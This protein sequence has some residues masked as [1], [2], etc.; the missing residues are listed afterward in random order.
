MVVAS[1]LNSGG[2]QD[3]LPWSERPNGPFGVSWT[4]DSDS[5][6]PGVIYM[7]CDNDGYVGLVKLENGRIDIAAALASGSGAA[8]GGAPVARVEAI[9]SR[10]E[11][12]KWSFHNPSQV[13]AT[14]P[15]R[16]SRVAGNG[17][18][19][20]IGDAAGYVEPFTGEGMT[21]AMQSGIAAADQIASV[22]EASTTTEISQVGDH[23]D[24]HLQK[25]LKSKKRTCRIVT[26]ALRRPIARQAAGQVLSRWPR[27]A[28]PLLQ[29]LSETT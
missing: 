11:F 23:W 8:T 29:K 14:P 19:L 18:V 10:S 3:I 16:R 28:K 2:Y 6:T 22:F 17:R 24:R 25:L 21:W 4:A 9:L 20:A 1:G 13:L 12:P 26:S 5:I 15:L 7:A 27:L